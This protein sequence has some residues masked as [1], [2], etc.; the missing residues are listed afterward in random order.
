[1]DSEFEQEQYVPILKT[2]ASPEPMDLYVNISIPFLVTRVELSNVRFFHGGTNY[3]YVLKARFI[4][5]IDNTAAIVSS[6]TFSSLE[7]KTT[8][9]LCNPSNPNGVQISGTY[10]IQLVHMEVDSNG[11]MVPQGNNNAPSA[12][13]YFGALFKFVGSADKTSRKR[14]IHLLDK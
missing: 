10:L 11:N 5:Q 6:S 1:M 14:L 3:T 2:F 7:P 9:N 12:Q 4:P 8:Y 13:T